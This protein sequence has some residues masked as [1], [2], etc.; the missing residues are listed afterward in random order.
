LLLEKGGLLLRTDKFVKKWGKAR[1]RGKKFYVMTACIIMG[2]GIFIGAIIGRL[3]TGSFLDLNN[4]IYLTGA[5]IGGLL[6]GAI[7]GIL[8]WN[9]NE[10]KYNQ[11]VHDYIEKV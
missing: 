7:G 1:K 8:K 9:S 10:E 4:L 6:G 2:L 3:V 5:L 11:F